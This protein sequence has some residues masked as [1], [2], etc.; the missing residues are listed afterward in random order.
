M[1]ATCLVQTDKDRGQAHGACKTWTAVFLSANLDFL[2]EPQHPCRAVYHKR[3]PNLQN[4]VWLMFFLLL[5]GRNL[6]VIDHWS[7]SRLVVCGTRDVTRFV[8]WPKH[9]RLK[10]NSHVSSEVSEHMTVIPCCC[11]LFCWW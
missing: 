9:I 10:S 2:S 11:V 7:F 6:V 3:V 1:T 5:W 4:S 8:K